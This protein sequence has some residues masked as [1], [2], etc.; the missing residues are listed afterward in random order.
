MFKLQ[1]F[2]EEDI[3]KQ[4]IK[5]LKKGI[6]SLNK[7]IAIHEEKISN[8]EMFYP[9]EWSNLSNAEKLGSI[10]HWQKEI[11][12]ARKSIFDRIEELKKRGVEID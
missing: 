5:S 12:N 11:E 2:A 7:I 3:S 4:S 10:K 9:D 6:R 1:I 8:P